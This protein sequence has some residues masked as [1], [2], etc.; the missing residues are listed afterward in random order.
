VLTPLVPFPPHDG[1]KLRLYHFLRCLRKQGHV[2]DLFCLTRVKGDL[3]QTQGLRDLC[4]RVHVEHL[5]NFDLFFNL[6]GGLITGQS[7]NVSAYFS[8]RFREALRVYGKST[9]GQKVD[10]VLAHRLRMAPWAF[11]E[12]LKRPV[13]L[14]LTDCL[15]AYTAKVKGQAGVGLFSR[16]IAWWDHWFL[17]KEE[18]EWAEKSFRTLVTSEADAGEL[19]NLGLGPE[20]LK[21]IPNGILAPSKK[22]FPRPSWYPKD[23]PVVCFAGNMGYLPNEDGALWFLREVWPRVKEGVPGAIFAAVGGRPS[24]KLRGHGNGRDVWVTWWVPEI[25]PYVA[26]A[27]LSVAP[28]RVAVGMQNKVAQSLSLGTPV[29]A[30]FPAAAWLPPEGRPFVVAA[31]GPAA[32]AQ[33][34]IQTLE[35]PRLAKTRALKGKGFIL[36]NF[37][38]ESSGKKLEDV[39]KQA[40]KQRSL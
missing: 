31:E 5:G 12:G 19:M 4:R 22:P 11:Q 35:K 7:L 23:K 28:L 29:V 37:A 30:T 32:F 10:V 26:H 25:E 18:K 2:I 3:V 9:E 21:V 14:E 39:L 40:E 6:M 16:A 8:P 15:T 33:A 24:S 13:I 27:A 36:K 17:Q 1:D 38:W 20:K 34:V